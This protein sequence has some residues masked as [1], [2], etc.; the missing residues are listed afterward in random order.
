LGVDTRRDGGGEGPIRALPYWNVD[1]SVK[2]NIRISE[3]FSTEFQFLFLNVMNHLVFA[4]PTLDISNP[5]S[6]GVLNTQG[7]TP[8]QMEFGLRV[9]F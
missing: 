6:W 3:R 8:R 9:R 4:N 1:L 2:K 7:N 5:A